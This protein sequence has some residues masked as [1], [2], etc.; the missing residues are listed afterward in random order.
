[1]SFLTDLPISY[2]HESLIANHLFRSLHKLFHSYYTLLYTHWL[3]RR[4]YYFLHVDPTESKEVVV[5]VNTEK[6]KYTLL[7]RQQNAE[8]NR[9]RDS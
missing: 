5:E 4:K 8:Q 7:S 6:T 1:V 2:I 3:T 9:D